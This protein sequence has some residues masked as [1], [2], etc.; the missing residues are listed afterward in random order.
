MHRQENHP[1]A[2]TQTIHILPH[3]MHL[4]PLGTISLL[5]LLTGS[6]ALYQC[7]GPAPVTPPPDLKQ[8]PTSPLP[9]NPPLDPAHLG[10][11]NDFSTLRR[12][13]LQIG[14]QR[15]DIWIAETSE[16]LAF[17]L[18]WVQPSQLTDTQG[19]LFVYAKDQTSGFWMKGTLLPL[20]I[21][22]F[23]PDGTI[24]DIQQMQPLTLQEHKPPTPYRYALEVKAGTFD[25]LN[26]HPGQ[27]I[28]IPA[29]A[30]ASPTS[31]D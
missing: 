17:G 21:A 26:V 1:M 14:S 10:E 11:M 8:P 7:A 29:E 15:F 3:G 16:Q 30:L 12:T 6:L 28:H 23:Q 27:I 18:A 5:L 20:D 2:R 25:R 13:P 9:S 4:N 19:M 24:L 22:F 31:A